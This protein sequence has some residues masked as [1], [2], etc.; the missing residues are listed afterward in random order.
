VTL[1][2]RRFLREHPSPQPGEVDAFLQGRDVPI[3][4][5]TTITFVWRGEADEVILRHPIYGIAATQ[6]FERVD[7]SALWY[8]LLDVPR[9]SRV[10]YK[11]EVVRNGSRELLVDPLNERVAHDPF[12][13]NSVCHTEGYRVPE[14]TR[15][16]PE[17][18][19]GSLEEA[20][21]HS[22][23]LGNHRPVAVYLPARLRRTRRYPLLIVLDGHEYVRYAGLKT[24]LDNLIHRYEIPPM[25]V[26]LTT[27]PDRMGE[28]ME[29]AEHS[30]F[31]ADELLPHLQRHFPLRDQPEQ[32]CLMGASLGAV[33]SLHCAWTHPGLFGRLLLQSGSFGFTDIGHDPR[34]PAHAPVVDFVNAFREAPGRFAE[35]VFLSCGV[36]E[37]VIYENRSLVPVL[38]EAEIETRFVEARDGHNW[39]NWRDRL[40]QG[41]TWLFPGPLALVYE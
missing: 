9:R 6:P 4:E 1:A 24:V 17:A 26:A 37:G 23:V 10:E 18:R 35:R 7:G 39:E 40:R 32:R 34:N 30:R 5:G 36:Y 29:P 28:Y 27:S 15:E 21:F 3:V 16:D 11:I 12:G 38:Q 31:L 13:T 22:A 8:L 25:I 14:W 33:A 20:S 41:L 19:R 2:I